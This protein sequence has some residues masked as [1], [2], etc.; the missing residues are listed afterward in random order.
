MA[1]RPCR[2]SKQWEHLCQ[3]EG[4]VEDQDQDQNVK[5]SLISH[6]THCPS[7]VLTISHHCYVI[8]QSQYTIVTE[9][10]TT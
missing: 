3:D 8:V 4:G 6:H 2:L 7:T 1:W 9:G 5:N 10:K